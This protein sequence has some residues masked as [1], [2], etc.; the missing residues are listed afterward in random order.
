MPL[1]LYLDNCANSE[2][3]ADL[4]KRAGHS[5][6]RPADASIGLE[7][8]DDDVH[9]AFAA[10]NHLA[11]VT[12]NPSDF[13]DLHDTDPN[14]FEILVVY[15]DNDISRD[16]SDPEIVKAISN[17]ESTH[18]WRTDRGEGF[19]VSTIGGI[20]TPYGSRRCRIR[21]SRRVCGRMGL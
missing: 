18:R 9:F 12:K 19:T 1:N 13:K 2:L 10:A 21:G 3:L 14:H 16:T 4:L 5:V 17:L 15:Q 7:G 8:E 11:I 6:A 20:D